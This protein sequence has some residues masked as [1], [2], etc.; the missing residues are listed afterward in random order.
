VNA[1]YRIAQTLRGFPIPQEAFG[2]PEPQPEGVV[3]RC[4]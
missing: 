2:P 1:G 4:C 3:A